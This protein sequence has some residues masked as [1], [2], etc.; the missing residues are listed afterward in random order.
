MLHA[1]ARLIGSTRP[2]GS[3]LAVPENVDNLWQHYDQP[4]VVVLPGHDHVHHVRRWA[5]ALDDLGGVTL[6]G[7]GNAYPTPGIA[8]GMDLVAD[9]HVELTGRIPRTSLRLTVRA[10]VTQLPVPFLLPPSATAD[11]PPPE[12]WQR[13]GWIRAI[14]PKL[15]RQLDDA[16]PLLNPLGRA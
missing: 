3:R 8:G 11:S 7:I 10:S 13:A 5:D 16:R 4:V 6:V 2:D 15:L 1:I 12:G 14:T 9:T